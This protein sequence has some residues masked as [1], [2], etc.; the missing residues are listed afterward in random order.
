MS[1]L[2]DYFSFLVP[3][4]VVSTSHSFTHFHF[5]ITVLTHRFPT[6]QK[7]YMIYPFVIRD[8]SLFTLWIRRQLMF[9]HHHRIIRSTLSQMHLRR[10]HMCGYAT[11]TTCTN[12]CTPHFNLGQSSHSFYMCVGRPLTTRERG[13]L[14]EWK[15]AENDVRAIAHSQERIGL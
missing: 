11:C 15:C 12:E 8:T 1:A 9:T 7:K 5:S 13:M 10:A 6:F 2:S 3:H 14:N 4:T